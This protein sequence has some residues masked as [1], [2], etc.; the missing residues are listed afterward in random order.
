MVFGNSALWRNA[1]GVLVP[2]TE[3]KREPRSQTV[4]VKSSPREQNRKFF[5]L[6]NARSF[7][8]SRGAHMGTLGRMGLLLCFSDPLSGSLER[9]DMHQN[10]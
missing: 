8:E 9:E 5:L 3:E 1:F 10:S 6:S 2:K 7:L 4:H